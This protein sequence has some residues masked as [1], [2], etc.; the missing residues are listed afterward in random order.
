V[1]RL[2]EHSRVYFFQNG[3]TDELN[4]EY[5]IGSA[6]WMGR[7]LHRRV[8][9]IAPIEERADRQVCWEMFQI[10]LNDHRQAWEMQPDGTYLQLR[11]E[12]SERDGTHEL[13]MRLTREQVTQ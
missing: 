5:F 6:D 7:N 13:L 1:G 8:E 3:Q 2:L 4:S 11:G 9:V 10:M 12:G